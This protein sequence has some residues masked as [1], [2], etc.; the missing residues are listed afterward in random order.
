VL[1][2]YGFE[3]YL[4]GTDVDYSGLKTGLKILMVGVNIASLCIVLFLLWRFPLHGEKWEDVQ[5]RLKD[6]RNNS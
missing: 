4:V 3:N 5:K 6:R 1:T 2:G